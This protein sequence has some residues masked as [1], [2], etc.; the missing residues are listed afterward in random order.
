MG[1]K[2]IFSDNVDWAMVGKGV[3][4][5]AKGLAMSGGAAGALAICLSATGPFGLAG[6]AVSGGLLFAES[7]VGP[8]GIS[9]IRQGIR[10]LRAG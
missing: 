6:A 3:V 5:T 7:K 10:A 4:N 9:Q 8:H 2:D 1:L